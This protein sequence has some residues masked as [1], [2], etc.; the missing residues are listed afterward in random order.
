MGLGPMEERIL[1]KLADG[2]A[3]HEVGQI[4]GMTTAAVRSRIYRLCRR[5]GYESSIEAWIKLGFQPKNP[6][7]NKQRR[8]HNTP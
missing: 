3:P 8:K 7:P 6:A 5:F 2:W 4:L 1:Q